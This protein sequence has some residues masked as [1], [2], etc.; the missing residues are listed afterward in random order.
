MKGRLEGANVKKLYI[1][2]NVSMNPESEE[3]RMEVQD[4][5]HCLISV[6]QVRQAVLNRPGVAGA[7]LGTALSFINSLTDYL[8]HPL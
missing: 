2:T 6:L 5:Y 1:N 3:Q 8:S 4:A 7:V